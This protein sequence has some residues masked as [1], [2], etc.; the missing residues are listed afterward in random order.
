MP[1]KFEINKYKL[2]TNVKIEDEEL[3][4]KK[5]DSIKYRLAV[6]KSLLYLDTCTRPDY[7]IFYK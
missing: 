6:R 1:S 5:F 4:K 2:V 3:S 7:L